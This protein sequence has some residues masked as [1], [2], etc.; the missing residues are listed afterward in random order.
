M[1]SVFDSL[2]ASE[3]V[4]FIFPPSTLSLKQCVVSYLRGILCF[5]CRSLNIPMALKCSN[6]KRK[7]EI[8]CA[9]LSQASDKPKQS[10]HA[11]QLKWP[12]CLHI[13]LP[14]C[15]LIQPVLTPNT[16]NME[17][18]S[19]ALRLSH[20]CSVTSGSSP[21]KVRVGVVGCVIHRIWDVQVLCVTE[22]QLWKHSYFNPRDVIS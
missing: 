13:H 9:W 19:L 16:S 1:F 3:C 22:C 21:R 10:F 11:A 7:K 6:E 18:W 14:A 2:A 8:Q 20:P 15:A 17:A 5:I 4:F 12:V